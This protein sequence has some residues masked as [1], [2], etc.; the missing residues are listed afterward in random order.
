MT[1]QTL[2]VTF[3]DF[4]FYVLK[5]GYNIYIVFYFVLIEENHMDRYNI[6]VKGWYSVW[7]KSNGFE[8]FHELVNFDVEDRYII[9]T[10]N[11]LLLA[12]GNE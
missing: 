8:F 5:I 3:Y 6:I 4:N 2:I 1:C 7:F 11:D 10:F 12:I 9:T